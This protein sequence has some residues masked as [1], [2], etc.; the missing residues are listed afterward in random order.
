LRKAVI[1]NS[2]K[3]EIY[4]ICECVLNICN[5]NLKLS[6]AE[7]ENLAKYK[8]TFSRLLHKKTNLRDKRNL[9]VQ[10]GGFLQFLIPAIVSGIAS[11]VSSAISSSSNKTTK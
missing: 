11:I 9:L 3:E 6:R 10:K 2:S 1:K 7:F 4:A 8:G 5:G